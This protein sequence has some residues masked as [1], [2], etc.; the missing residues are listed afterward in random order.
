[1]SASIWT[2]ASQKGREEEPYR[3]Q[4]KLLLLINPFCNRHRLQQ[5]ENNLV[6]CGEDRGFLVDRAVHRMI[7]YTMRSTREKTEIIVVQ[8]AFGL[9]SAS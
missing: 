3:V 5:E 9:Q 7:R 4:N 1:V 6:N 2:L 8:F